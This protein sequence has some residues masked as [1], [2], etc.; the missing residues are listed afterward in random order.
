M[1]VR[2]QQLPKA[3]SLS[4][5]ANP[6]RDRLAKVGNVFDPALKVA[7][8]KDM[9]GL[10]AV[11]AVAEKYESV[12]K[13]LRCQST[14]T[15]GGVGTQLIVKLETQQ[16][17]ATLLGVRAAV[18]ALPKPLL[19]LSRAFPVVGG[20]LVLAAEAQVSARTRTEVRARPLPR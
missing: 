6:K 17:V 15:G 2:Q 12:R 1:V 10:E 5:Y 20:D 11:G 18:H 13:V 14:Q 19:Q 4:P 9:E 16:P 7:P 3:R 8:M